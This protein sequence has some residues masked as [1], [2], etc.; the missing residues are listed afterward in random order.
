MKCMTFESKHNLFSGEYEPISIEDLTSM[1][2]KWFM[3]DFIY[4][5]SVGGVVETDFRYIRRVK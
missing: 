3:E 2:G 5:L 4:K 1:F